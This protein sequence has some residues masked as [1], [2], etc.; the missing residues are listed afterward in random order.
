MTTEELLAIIRK[1]GPAASRAE[2][3]LVKQYEPLLRTLIGEFA[4]K[5]R[6][7]GHV[8]VDGDDFRQQ[9]AMGL[10]YLARRFDPNRGKRFEQLAE[11]TIRDFMGDALVEAR[12]IP[13]KEAHRRRRAIYLGLH[14][15]AEELGDEVSSF[16][17]KTLL[18]KLI[19]HEE[20][21]RK[22]SGAYAKP[23]GEQWKTIAANAIKVL[24]TQGAAAIARERNQILATENQTDLLELDAPTGSGEDE[25][26]LL[27]KQPAAKPAESTSD[28]AELHLRR[29]RETV[30][31]HPRIGDQE[32]VVL[33]E[34]LR[35]GPERPSQGEVGATLKVTHQRVQQI[36]G[37]ALRKLHAIEKAGQVVAVAKSEPEEPPLIS[38]P[39]IA[40]ELIERGL[41]RGNALKL[42]AR[43]GQD[44]LQARLEELKEQ[45]ITRIRLNSPELAQLRYGVKEDPEKQREAEAQRTARQA[46]VKAQI[47]TTMLHPVTGARIYVRTHPFLPILPSVSKAAFHPSV[48]RSWQV[49]GFFPGA[50]AIGEKIR[51]ALAPHLAEFNAV[52]ARYGVMVEPIDTRTPGQKIGQN[53]IHFPIELRLR[54]INEDLEGSRGDRAFREKFETGRLL[55]R[56]EHEAVD[57]AFEELAEKASASVQRVLFSHNGEVR[58][59]KEQDAYTRRQNAARE[60]RLL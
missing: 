28:V 54:S 48:Y 13:L 14:Q 41:P 43:V 7:Q 25:R 44:R 5:A 8:A 36:E 26:P 10:V 19:E 45:G 58:R 20:A 11:G 53:A 31:Q 30:R 12:T 57:R 21:R 3:A 27:E 47:L 60:R 49:A 50:G 52:N 38:T 29:L 34:R 55:R 32:K 56:A 16:N 17:E 33:L 22:L 15:L 6:M 23:I 9:G 18:A 51:Q 42:I 4:R 35:A 40:L 39:P 59:N 1:G 46:K 24:K 2:G 37:R